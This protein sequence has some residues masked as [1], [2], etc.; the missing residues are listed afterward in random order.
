MCSS[1]MLTANAWSHSI[2]CDCVCAIRW[3]RSA[4]VIRPLFHRR[5]RHVFGRAMMS[6]SRSG[7]RVA[8]FLP[9]TTLTSPGLLSYHLA[10]SRRANVAHR[11]RPDVGWGRRSSRFG[12]IALSRRE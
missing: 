5:R 1:I 2:R 8:G 4:F 10:L 12:S 7:R 11:A 3:I 9:A 6:T